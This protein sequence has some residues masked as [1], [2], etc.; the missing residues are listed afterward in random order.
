MYIGINKAGP[1]QSA[2][3]VE[4]KNTG[5]VTVSWV[6]P[7]ADI[8]GNPINPDF[9]SYMI[10]YKSPGQTQKV[11]G[12]NIKGTS[13]T[14]RIKEESEAQEFFTFLV[15]TETQ[16]GVNDREN[17]ATNTIP[18]G[19]PDEMPYHLGFGSTDDPP[20]LTTSERT[21]AKWT[22]SSDVEDQIGRAHV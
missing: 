7:E 17:V 8:D 16:A 12:R 20:Y 4:T 11:A 13:Y 10:I 18:V 9:I 19:K 2:S 5:E 14:F 21:T 3:A 6:A 15:F 1:V 22:E